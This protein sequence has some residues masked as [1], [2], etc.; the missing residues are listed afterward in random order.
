VKKRHLILRDPKTRL[1]IHTDYLEISN[2]ANSYVVAFRHIG[3]VYLN[4]AIP[5][6]IGACYA[7]CRRVP[8][9]LI[10]QNGYIVARVAEVSDAEV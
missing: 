6:T 3:A 8:L 10:D 2:P 5:L 7:I 9:W 4:K 1:T